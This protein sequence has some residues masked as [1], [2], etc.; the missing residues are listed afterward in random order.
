M[1]TLKD[2]TCVVQVVDDGS[3]GPDVEKTRALVEGLR[4]RFGERLAPL[5]CLP[6]NQGKGAAV[7]AGWRAHPDAVQWGFVD[8][9]GSISPEEVCRVA[10]LALG[11]PTTAYF[12]SRIKMLGRKVD[13]SNLRHYYGRIFATL[14]SVLLHAGVY[15]SQC[16]FKIMPGFALRPR[17][18]HLEENGFA[19]DLE[20]LMEL[21]AQGVPIEE[22][23]IDWAHVSGS[24]VRILRDAIAMLMSLMR[25][26]RRYLTSKDKIA[27]SLPKGGL[28]V[29]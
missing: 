4:L 11:S 26:K 12:A 22:V 29:H 2:L 3:P 15:D 23:P 13:R 19:F 17:I 6:R 8:A 14:S 27:R 10:I 5:L 25:I 18:D 1:E 24:K 20:I 9:D 7:R 21:L 28:I 16:G